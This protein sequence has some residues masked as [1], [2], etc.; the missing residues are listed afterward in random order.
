MDSKKN[1]NYHTNNFFY[2]WQVSKKRPFKEALI[3]HLKNYDQDRN[4]KAVIF[5]RSQF[6]KNVEK[7]FKFD[8]LK[9]DTIKNK[10]IDFIDP[11]MKHF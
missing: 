6:P 8:I 9:N 2:N 10:I 1:K 4:V 3:I 5:E 7:E 11:D